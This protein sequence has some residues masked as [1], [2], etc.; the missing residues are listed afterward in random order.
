MTESPAV[1][2]IS[3]WPRDGKKIRTQDYSLRGA[4]PIHWAD[5]TG[6]QGGK[7]MWGGEVGRRKPAAPGAVLTCEHVGD[8]PVESLLRRLPFAHGGFHPRTSECPDPGT[9]PP[10]PALRR[11]RD[12]ERR[13][14]TSPAPEQPARA[15]EQWLPLTGGAA[16]GASGDVT[17]GGGA[18][19]GLRPRYFR[20]CRS[21]NRTG[22]VE[23][24]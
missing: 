19:A 12:L 21:G 20:L 8:P 9:G 18:G 11:G 22:R 10:L 5:G 6:E 1:L 3:H 16:H 14:R 13:S 24:T 2:T 23:K 17:I 7:A 4:D 15:A